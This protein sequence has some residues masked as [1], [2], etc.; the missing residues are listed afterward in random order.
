MS[1]T[2]RT[3]LTIATAAVLS[4]PA[5]AG[6]GQPCT[7]NAEECL[8]HIEQ[9]RERGW[10]GLELDRSEKGV[11]TVAKVVP[12]SPAAASGFQVGDALVALDGINLYDARRKSDLEAVR[13]DLRPGTWVTYT[14]DRAGRE[15][16]VKTILARMPESVF[17]AYRDAHMAEHAVIAE[18]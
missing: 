4:V 2:L 7:A 9:A 1:R 16:K 11:L 12:G 8:K 13:A 10:I 15:K 18:K 14:V 3:V 17:T 5:L 6:A